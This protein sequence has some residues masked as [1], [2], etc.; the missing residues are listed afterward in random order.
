MWRVG[1]DV[2]ESGRPERAVISLD[3]IIRASH[4]LGDSANKPLPP[5]VT[6]VNALD[7]FK[8]LYVN[9]YVDHHAYEIAS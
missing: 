9:K 5:G 1:P 7:E 2:D 3:T 4:L 6:Y 8:A